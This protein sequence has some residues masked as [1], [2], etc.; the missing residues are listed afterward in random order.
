MTLP[1]VFDSASMYLASSSRVPGAASRPAR[2][3]SSCTSADFKAL[4][5]SWFRRSRTGA[6]VLPG[7]TKAYQ[8]V[9]VKRQQLGHGRQLGQEGRPRQPVVASGTSLPAAMCG[10]AVDMV[11][12]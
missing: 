1:Q 7:A 6:G 8:L 2:V 5:S 4:T 10:P 11:A 3:S 12:K 9:A